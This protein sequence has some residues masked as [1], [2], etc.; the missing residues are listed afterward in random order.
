MFLLPKKKRRHVLKTTL[1]QGTGYPQPHSE[2]T[3]SRDSY[4]LVSLQQDKSFFFQYEC[5]LS[6]YSLKCLQ[7]PWPCTCVLFLF[8]YCFSSHQARGNKSL[9]SCRA[10]NLW[11]SQT[12]LSSP[13]NFAFTHL[14][15]PSGRHCE[16]PERGFANVC[17]DHKSF[18]QL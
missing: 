2:S 1:S 4:F 3:A 12:F 14:A 7:Y 10:V 9:R 18:L 11:Q 15:C 13:R 17:D 16:K 6:F 5:E 8:C